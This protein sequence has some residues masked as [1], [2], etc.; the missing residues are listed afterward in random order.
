M[1]VGLISSF[2]I[3]HKGVYNKA[4]TFAAIK[5]GMGI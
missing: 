5:K 4:F 2:F 3:Y 1:S